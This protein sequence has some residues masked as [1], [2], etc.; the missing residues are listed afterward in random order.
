[1]AQSRA[2]DVVAVMC[3]QD[4]PQVEEWLRGQGATP[5]DAATVR[6]KVMAAAVS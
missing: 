5:D 6:R 3:H 1:M 4:R 2:D